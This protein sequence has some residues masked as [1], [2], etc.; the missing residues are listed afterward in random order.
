M[1]EMTD[2]LTIDNIHVLADLY[3]GN[4]FAAS[5]LNSA[6]ILNRLRKNLNLCF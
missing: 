6:S 2:N 5:F 4:S 3:F 1:E